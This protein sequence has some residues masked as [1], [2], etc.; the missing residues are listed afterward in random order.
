M[1]DNEDATLDDNTEPFYTPEAQ[2]VGNSESKIIPNYMTEDTSKKG[3][4]LEEDVFEEEGE[5]GC[6]GDSNID[7]EDG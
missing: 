6:G 7:A 1:S 4:T 2:V 5:I 3:V